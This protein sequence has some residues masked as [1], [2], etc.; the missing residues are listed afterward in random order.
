MPIS[1]KIIITF[2]VL[3]VLFVLFKVAEP[4]QAQYGFWRLRTVGGLEQASVGEIIVRVIQW[5]M[6]IV[7]L[8]CVA[9]IICGGVMY[10]TSGG[11]E[12]HIT[13]AKKILLWS[14]I[15]LIICILAFTIAAAVVGMIGGEEGVGGVSCHGDTL[16]TDVKIYCNASGCIGGSCSDAV[17][18]SCPP[19][20][21][22]DKG[23]RCAWGSEGG[24]Q[25]S[26][27]QL[28]CCDPVST[29]CCTS[30]DCGGGCISPADQ[31]KCQRKCVKTP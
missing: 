25:G 5:I 30:G 14:I 16:S 27:G 23:L 31:C 20:H 8:I 2:L 26:K 1:K 13:R 7:G 15:G 24:C 18:A 11:S 10:A 29:N 21:P 28:W 6:G 4:A 19:S 12:E 3:A 22:I 9:F 17:P